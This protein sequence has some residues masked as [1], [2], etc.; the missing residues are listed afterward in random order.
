LSSL[1]RAIT[2]LQRTIGDEITRENVSK[3]LTPARRSKPKSRAG[4]K[5]AEDILC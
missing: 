4:F 3:T 5:I 2:L 1:P